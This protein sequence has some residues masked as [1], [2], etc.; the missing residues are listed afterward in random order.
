MYACIQIKAISFDN[1]G[2]LITFRLFVSAAYNWICFMLMWT[3][4]AGPELYYH[5]YAALKGGGLRNVQ[6]ALNLQLKKY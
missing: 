3:A 6:T 2:K 5:F 4:S 1:L